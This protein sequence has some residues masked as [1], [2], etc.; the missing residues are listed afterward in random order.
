MGNQVCTVSCD[1]DNENAMQADGI[2]RIK[3]YPKERR[4]ESGMG[5]N[6]NSPVVYMEEGMHS[7][8]KYLRDR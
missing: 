3:R 1:R 5:T 8:V 4:I 2:N 6:M 7:K